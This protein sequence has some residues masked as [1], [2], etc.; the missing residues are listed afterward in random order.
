MAPIRRSLHAF[1]QLVLGIALMAVLAAAS[2][3]AQTAKYPDRPI[4]MVVGFTAGGG[5]DVVARILSQKM[6]ETLG[7]TVL[8]ENRTA[9]PAHL[10]SNRVE[11]TVTLLKGPGEVE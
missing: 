5:T 1:V 8:V 10:R 3:Q 6:S 9:A 11:G 7:Q 2:A 4:K